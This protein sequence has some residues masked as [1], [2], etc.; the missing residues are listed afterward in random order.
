LNLSGLFC[1]HRRTA[2]LVLQ[3]LVFPPSPW[4]RPCFA[5]PNFDH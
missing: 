4:M 1:T 2:I 5:C 3:Y